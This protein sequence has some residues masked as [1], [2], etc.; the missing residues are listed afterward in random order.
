MRKAVQVIR[1]EHQ[2]LAALLRS[3]SLL[4]DRQ[5][6]EGSAPAFDALRAMLFYIDEFPE[7]RHHKKE[8]DILFP[9]L[10]ARAPLHRSLLDRLDAE[11]RLGESR[12]RELEH[13]LTACEMM[14]DRRRAAFEDTA[15]QYVDFY[16]SHMSLE[17]REVLP[18]AERV[19]TEADW[20]ELDSAFLE[21][22][23]A[24]AGAEPD[25]EYAAL[26]HRIVRLVP[27]PVGLGPAAW[28]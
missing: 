14:G 17:E 25:E 16:L 2:A 28:P 24:L 11:H 6:R 26:F 8:T 22:R 4:I 13:A 21:N 27:A 20:S 15:A 19:L 12:I 7:K 5:R 10:R 23:D 18:L 1:M 9:K 3:V